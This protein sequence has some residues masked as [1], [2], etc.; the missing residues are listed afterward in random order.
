M[1]LC[2]TDS[3]GIYSRA[4]RTAVDLGS[5]YTTAVPPGESLNCRRLEAAG[6]KLLLD[7]CA[8]FRAR[9]PT[10]SRVSRVFVCVKS[11][12]VCTHMMDVFIFIR[13]KIRSPGPAHDTYPLG[14]HVC[15][16]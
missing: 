9:A 7:Y 15:S 6:R 16:N 10:R 5:S 12:H 14:K 3:I 1:A 4:T 11:L 2:R 8:C 13:E